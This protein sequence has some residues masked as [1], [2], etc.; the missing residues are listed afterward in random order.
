MRHRS[1]RGLLVEFV[2]FLSMSVAVPSGADRVKNVDTSLEAERTELC[3]I[4]THA[5]DLTVFQLRER[6]GRS[7]ELG[8][9]DL[10][11]DILLQIACRYMIEK[12][13]DNALSA[14]AQIIE[15]YPKG[16]VLD[17]RNVICRSSLNSTPETTRAHERMSRY[18]KENPYSTADLAATISARICLRRNDY[19][20]CATILRTMIEGKQRDGSFSDTLTQACEQVGSGSETNLPREIVDQVR[21]QPDKDALH[22]LALCYVKLGKKDDARKIY[23]LAKQRF[24]EECPWAKEEL[25]LLD[26]GKVEDL[27]RKLEQAKTSTVF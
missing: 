1:T 17:Q 25:K 7:V 24:P 2:I 20:K 10:S 26:E 3:R 22:V 23:E 9:T 13:S 4:G 16:K 15:Q 12:E 6:L 5:P 14:L 11:D 19:D 27:K 8:F 21:S 18:L